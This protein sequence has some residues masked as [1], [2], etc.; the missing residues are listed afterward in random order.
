MDILDRI[1]ARVNVVLET[2]CWEWQGRK[3]GRGN[4]KYGVIDIDSARH[5]VHRVVYAEIN[6]PIPNGMGVLHRC[7]NPPCC[8]PDHL[9]LGTQLVNIRDAKAKGR[10]S[11]GSSRHNAKLT[12]RDV[13]AIVASI[14]SGEGNTDI[15]SRY[16]VAHQT[17]HNIRAGY[18]WSH[19]TAGMIR[20]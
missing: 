17:I 12:E 4:C 11:H 9:F 10:V 16:A 20:G 13:H 8:N 18:T 5:L 15:A 2:G 1:G 7:D 3:D 14:N 6:G 19:I